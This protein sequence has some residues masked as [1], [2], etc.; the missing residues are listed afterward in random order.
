ME[1][2]R[3]M[4]PVVLMLAV[5]FICK[6][7][8][9][10]KEEGMEAIRKYI[11]LIALPTTIFHSMAI[12]DINKDTLKILVAMFLVLCV[13][14]AIGFLLRTVIPEPY[15]PYLPFVTTVFEGGMFAYPLYQNL[16]GE[17]HFVNVVIVDMAGCVFGF[18]L[19][20][21]ILALVDQ[22][23]KFSVKLLASTAAKS[24]TFWGMVAGLLLN[25]TGVMKLFLDTE[26]SS[27]YLAVKDLVVAPL[28]A[29]ILLY[30]GF[31]LKMDK[32]LLS[33]CLKS[34]GIRIVTMA[35]LCFT[36]VKIFHQTVEDTYMLAAFLVYFIS[37]PTFSL[38][39]FVKNKE[40]AGYFAMTT[41]VYVVI[42]IIGYAVIAT[43]L[44]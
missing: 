10:F 31:S 14:M 28:T 1:T 9:F 29:M 25:A 21:G 38:P 26:V 15:K 6:K 19:F 30:V 33:V 8:G 34:I 43:V 5:G 7:T 24:P 27:I 13:A 40:A 11:V 16:C 12:A 37:T 35:T 17:E 32:S 3:V 18:G 39:G 41:S 42:T 2:V 4:L 22:K 23:Q 36:V 20:Y 44:F